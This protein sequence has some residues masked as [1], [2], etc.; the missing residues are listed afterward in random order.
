MYYPAKNKELKGYPSIR[1]SMEEVTP[2]YCYAHCAPH[3][4]T[5]GGKKSKDIVSIADNIE[6]NGMLN[7]LIGF[8]HTGN[9]FN[10]ELYAE[11][12]SFLK[13]LSGKKQWATYMKAKYF[14]KC[15]CQR[16][17]A[18]HLLGATETDIIVLDNMKTILELDE[19]CRTSDWR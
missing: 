12:Y 5:R 11:H 17:Y 10:G 9:K 7:P 15:G 6:D 4:I 13:H 2:L 18:L 16:V 8:I 1:V 3:E 19:V 14:I